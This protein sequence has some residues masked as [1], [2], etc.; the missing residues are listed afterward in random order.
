MPQ[1]GSRVTHT[2]SIQQERELL[3]QPALPWLTLYQFPGL[4]QL[5]WNMEWIL[6]INLMLSFIKIFVEIDI[7]KV[8]FV[9][10][11]E[12]WLGRNWIM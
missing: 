10:Q 2:Q 9:L 5:G 3:T 4:D 6:A 1:W 7:Q 12:W 8:I 11:V